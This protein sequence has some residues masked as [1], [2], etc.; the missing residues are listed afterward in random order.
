MNMV[1]GR[2]ATREVVMQAEA[3][4]EWSWLLPFNALS[5]SAGRAQ[6]TKILRA[7]GVGQSTVDDACAVL[8]E[9]L[10]NSVRHARPRADGQVLVTMVLDNASVSVAVADGG[11]V[12]VPAL[13]HPAPLA[14]DGRGLGIVH[15]LTRDWGVH[16]AAEGN[17]VFG[18]LSRV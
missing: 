15:T 1:W 13:R 11:G 7:A 6:V 8:T 12:T 2:V 18:V 5:A 16:A 10:A 9:L 14:P 17:T 3:V 4:G